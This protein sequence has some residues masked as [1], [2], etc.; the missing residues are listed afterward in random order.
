M[1]LSFAGG[2]GLFASPNGWKRSLST[3]QESSL[4]RS[5][6]ALT[7]VRDCL[8]EN[9]T[10]TLSFTLS[11]VLISISSDILGVSRDFSLSVFVHLDFGS[12]EDCRCW[13]MLA[14]PETG[15]S[16]SEPYSSSTQYLDCWDA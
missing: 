5:I 9:L 14:R 12:R 15:G 1:S 2:A 11:D 8:V 6:E 16:K 13:K 4:R 3:C 7:T 10:G